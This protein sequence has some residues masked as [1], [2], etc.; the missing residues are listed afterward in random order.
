M[1]HLASDLIERL[2]ERLAAREVELVTLLHAASRQA[3]D[4][5]DQQS[6]DVQDFKDIAGHDAQAALEITT[7]WHAAQ[8]LTEVTAAR[9][10][11]AHG[12][13]GLCRTCGE[14]IAESR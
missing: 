10:R 5:A 14:P 2:D 9:R 4:A 13:Y 1:P 7:V 3:A 12:S 8:E 11:L 6:H